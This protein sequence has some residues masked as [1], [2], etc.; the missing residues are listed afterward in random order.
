MSANEADENMKSNIQG[1]YLTE[2]PLPTCLGLGRPIAA[3]YYWSLELNPPFPAEQGWEQAA[4]MF[5][6]QS[7]VVYT[8]FERLQTT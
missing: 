1:A 3:I 2:D 5:V 4:K 6:Q 8:L 7:N